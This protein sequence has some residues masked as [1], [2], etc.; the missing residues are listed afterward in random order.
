MSC[1]ILPAHAG[2][3]LVEKYRP[4]TLSEVVGQQVAI[5]ALQS[6]LDQPF[7]S[8][9]I[10]DGPTG[11]GK[12][13]AAR[14]LAF[15]L[16]CSRE[17]PDM[18]G[19]LEIPSGKQ[20][21][22]AV[23]DLLRNLS[24]RPLFGSGWNVAIVNEADLMTAQAE[25]IWLDGL[26][27]L[28]PRSVIV[29]TTNELRRLSN[30]LVGRCERIAFDGSSPEFTA[31]LASL[32]KR[33]WKAETGRTLRKMPVNLG[34]YELASDTYSI[35]LALQQIAPYIRSGEQP[36]AEITVPF[37]R[38][39]ETIRAEVASAAAKK[40]WKTRLAKECA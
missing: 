3:G 18:G 20:D 14:A 2:R 15:D 4:T 36:P 34:R 27:H 25:A 13:A 7:P 24:R 40:A 37:V 12:T 30:R 9:F 29:F 32:V 39:E 11:V 38:D 6:Y 33:I 35:R 5:A 19:L 8:A 1:S 16:G 28:P 21:G 26:E 10:F 31:G 17:D 22:K 23:E